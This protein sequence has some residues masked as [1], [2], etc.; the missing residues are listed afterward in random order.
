[1][2]TNVNQHPRAIDLPSGWALTTLGEIADTT[3]E[4]ANPQEYPHLRFIG[5]EHIEPHTTRL[6][7]TAPTTEMRSSAEHF[8]PGDVLYGRLRPYL[9]KLLC[10]A[11]DP[12]W[13]DEDLDQL[14]AVPGS[15]FE[16]VDTGPI[17]P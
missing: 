12:R 6:L 16:A 11:T 1:M 17:L 3:H 8:Y 14:K 2:T 13:D 4:R 7:T 9:H 10:G 5:M 15:A